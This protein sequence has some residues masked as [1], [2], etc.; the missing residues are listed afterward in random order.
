MFTNLINYMKINNLSVDDLMETKVTT[1][2]TLNDTN[3]TTNRVFAEGITPF[4]AIDGTAISPI[5]DDATNSFTEIPN[6][7]TTHDPLIGHLDGMTLAHVPGGAAAGSELVPFDPS[8]G[9]PDEEIE[10][11]PNSG[12]QGASRDLDP[13]GEHSR[14]QCTYVCAQHLTSPR[15]RKQQAW[16]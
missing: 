10:D 9:S 7:M 11:S 6:D 14:P 4:A 2:T 12:L 16:L 3:Y 8:T 5:N 1:E 15:L 13:D